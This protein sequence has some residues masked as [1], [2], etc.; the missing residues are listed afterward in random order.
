[1]VVAVVVVVVVPE[2]V[3]VG[4]GVAVGVVAVVGVGDVVGGDAVGA[5]VVG[6]VAVADVAALRLLSRNQTLICLNEIPRSRTGVFFCP[7]VLS[8]F[9]TSM[10]RLQRPWVAFAIKAFAIAFFR[11]CRL[12]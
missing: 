10:G 12:A 6:V 8:G 5:D 7:R 11:P 9:N 1:V 4:V 3:V 2:D